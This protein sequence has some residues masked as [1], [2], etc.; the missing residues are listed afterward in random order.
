[1]TMRSLKP[2]SVT[3]SRRL[4]QVLAA[5]ANFVRLIVFPDTTRPLKIHCNNKPLPHASTLKP[6]IQVKLIRLLPLL[7]VLSGCVTLL[8]AT[9]QGP[10]DPEPGKRSL[11]QYFSDENLETIIG[12]NL[13]KAS[14][15]LAEAHVNIRAF[16]D[17]VLLTG[18][19]P[20]KQ[21][22]R[23][24]SETVRNIKQVRQV[25]NELTVQSNSTFF[26]RTND[27]WLATKVRTKFI[28]NR[29][30][31]AER[32]KVVVENRVVYLMGLVTRKEATLIG[33]VA[34]TADGVEKVVRV[35]EYID[36]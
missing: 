33:Q 29:D 32:I 36:S 34:A 14:S 26:S 12:V 3:S 19:V 6:R 31:E 8:D 9:N 7:F 24:A 18:E 17:V 10:I 28:V 5:T 25:H 13:R 35:F 1:M 11:G 30:I 21:L 16:N 4:T 15:A 23:I 20:S 22:R 27:N 2:E